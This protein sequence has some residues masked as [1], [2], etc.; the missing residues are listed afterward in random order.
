[1][2]GADR[3][4]QAARFLQDAHAARAAYQP[5]PEAFAP[6]DIDEAYDIQ[7]AFQALLAAERG[8]ISGYKIA[9]TTPVMQKMVGFGHPCFGAVFAS[10]V[11]HSPVT[12]KAS[13]Y[14]H[15]GA[16]CEIAALLSRDLPAAAAPYDRETVA[17][18]VA[19]LMP[20]FELV[21]D[22]GA[23][24]SDLF[25]LGVAADNAWNAGVVLGEKV[26]D[27]RGIDLV[28][29]SGAMT[30]NGQPAGEGK[31]GDVLG[32]PLEALAWLANTLAQRGQSLKKDMIVMTGSIVSTKFLN[33]GD[34]VR[35]DIP[36]LG[37]V[38]LTVG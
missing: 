22:R 11:H 20:A 24:Y 13:D 32:H 29:A 1:M 18:A 5:L 25:F 15:I 19:A 9:L 26:T 31:G 33:Q 6:R 30:I 4:Q 14:V 36:E 27:W 12:V 8:P 16:E 7:E 23:D 21:D 2:A 28:A 37:E 38:R 35:F 34:D 10:V 3:T 17:G